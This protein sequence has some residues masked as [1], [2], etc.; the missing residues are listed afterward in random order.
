M[1]EYRGYEGNSLKFLKTN[2]ISIGDS[3]KILADITYSGII[4]PRYEHS[5]DKHIVLKL[6]SGYNIGLEIEKI[7]KIEKIKSTEKIVQQD[8]KLEKIV[9]LPKILLLSTGGTI[10]SKIDY[11]TGAV[12]PVLTAEELNSSVPELAKIANIDAVVLLSEYSENIMPEHWLQIAEKINEYSKSDYSGIIIAHGTDTMHYT[13]S[14]LSFA[15]A[16]FPIPIVLVGSQRSSDRASS[17]AALNLIGATKFITESNTKG[18]YIVMHQDENDDTLAC[19][20]GTRVRKN[21]TSKRGAFQTIGNNPAFIIAENK[22]Q[23]NISEDFFK[24]SKFQPRI[25]LDTRVAL[26]K[27]HPGY[28]PELLDQIIEMGY[29]G[30]IFEGTGLGHIGN[31]M[32]ESVKKANEKGI[33]L[34]MTSQCIDGRIR[35][36]VYESGRDL[37]NLGIIPLENMIPEVALVKAMWAIGNF[38]NGEEIKKIMLEN[39]ASELSS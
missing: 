10:A 34:G 31:T 25:K 30:I 32:Y 27:Y 17:D 15:L 26:V 33:F 36:T 19:H 21:H 2:Q 22:I 39:I 35:M 13:S 9:G 20:I 24:I 1:S 28:N 5:D 18:I 29:K 12:T 4:M 3:V 16:G 8:E 7:E 11:R 23:K 6:T 38:Q 37:L 14:F